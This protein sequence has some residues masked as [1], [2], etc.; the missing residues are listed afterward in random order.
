MTPQRIQ[1]LAAILHDV[2]PEHAEALAESAAGV[3]NEF[4]ETCPVDV[5]PVTKEPY[6]L[7]PSDIALITY[8]N[9]IEDGTGNLTPLAALHDVLTRYQIMERLPIVHLLPFY[10]WDTDRGFSVKDYRQ[11]NPA[12]GTWDDV[13]RLNVSAKLMFDFVANHASIDNPLV[14][15]A[16]IERHLDVSDERYAAVAPYKNFVTAYSDDARPDD[17]DLAALSRPR[18]NPVLTRYTVLE[19]GGVLRALLGAAPAGAEVLGTGWVWTTFSRPQ[20]DDGSEDTRQVDLNFAEPQVFLETIK[21]LLFYISQGAELVR[22]DAIGYIWKKL[23]STS[24]HEP[25]AHTL[26]VAID[27]VL[28]W[29]APGV[30]S[31]AEVNEPQDKVFDYLGT[32]E[33][34][35]S[36]LV[37]QFT[38]FPLAV[39]AVL[40]GSGKHWRD[41]LPTADTFRGRQFITALGSHDGMGMKPVLGIVPDEEL[42]AFTKALVDEYGALPN[43]AKLPGGKEIVYETAA[44]PWNLINRPDSTE[45]LEVQLDRY[46]VV[47]AL[48]LLPRGVPALYINGLLGAENYQPAGGLDEHRTVNREVFDLAWL[49]EQLNDTTNRHRRVLDRI[50]A[51]LAL[52]AGETSFDADGPAP[53]VVDAG[54]DAVIAVRLVSPEGD[55]RLLSLI[56]V[57]QDAQE[58]TLVLD[59]TKR[60][61]V[62]NTNIDSGSP[63]T[64]D[65]YRIVWLVSV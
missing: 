37:Y 49:T 13:A 7:A 55:R 20:R 52:R 12:Y 16:L 3:V 35:E 47:L 61:L 56:N 59:E 64:L 24:L 41:W 18:P 8:A 19:E 30:I 15:G 44:T 65:P 9:S 36:D 38:H 42:E 4:I 50:L 62:S 28:S 54:N 33:R 51:L 39:L 5:R 25:E 14:Q 11:V 6:N 2:Y 60:D 53:E 45:A 23:G 48:G 27:E 26:L 31:I 32:A 29:A 63:V 10:P 40:T 34:R 21:I 22:L 43:Y 57:S 46:L 58:T 17:D 1:K